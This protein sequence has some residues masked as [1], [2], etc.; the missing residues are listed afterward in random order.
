MKPKLIKAGMGYLR[1]ESAEEVAYTQDMFET[2]FRY[3]IKEKDVH[4]PDFF[5][6]YSNIKFIAVCVAQQGK[7]S[8]A[9]LFF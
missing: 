8:P 5:R 6:I 2:I 9:G 4:T 7:S 3:Y 1:N